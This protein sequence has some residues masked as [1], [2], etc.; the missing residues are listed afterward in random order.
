MTLQ[1][2]YSAFED[3]K[4]DPEKLTEQID[5]HQGKIKELEFQ[6][7]DMKATVLACRVEENQFDNSILEIDFDKIRGMYD[8]LPFEKQK[9]LVNTFIHKIVIDPEWYE[10]R[11]SIPTGFDPDRFLREGPDSRGNSGNSGNCDNRTRCRGRGKNK[12]ATVSK[13][14]PIRNS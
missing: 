8:T 9:E 12:I 7:A 6:I 14:F 5:R 10:I 13:P 2:Y 4:L 3:D 11:Y 1:K